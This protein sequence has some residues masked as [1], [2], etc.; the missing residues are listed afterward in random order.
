MTK[1]TID[2]ERP[3]VVVT[4]GSG[5]LGG[6][7]GQQ[8]LRRGY[9][10]VLA[11]RDLGRLQRTAARLGEFG[12]VAVV[13]ADV[14]EAAGR[15]AMIAETLQAFGRLDVL[16]NNAGA[17]YIGRL[18][19][20]RLGDVQQM[21]ALNL[22]APIEL[23]RA[24]APIMDRVGGGHIINICTMAA[25]TPMTTMTV[26]GATK[27]GLGHFSQLLRLELAPRNI[28]VSAVY[29]GAIEGEG[30]FA[31]MQESTGVQFPKTMPTSAP[32]W[33]A[34]QVVTAVRRNR[35]EVF[36]APGGKVMARHPRTAGLLLR[37]LGVATAFAEVADRRD[38][39]RRE[40]EE[41]NVGSP[42]S[43]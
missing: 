26:Y 15:Q 23:A 13:S 36:A 40:P 2:E 16:V 38:M 6:S 21:A 17:E 22:V 5:A 39:E 10:V 37:R 12:P 25:K 33:V 18:D 32:E 29:P 1:S 11:A 9:R 14:T 30:M 43:R 34:E 7:I 4:G 31:D 35:A 41:L 20:H 42:T 28:G 3:V 27:A 19:Q 8:F 24:A